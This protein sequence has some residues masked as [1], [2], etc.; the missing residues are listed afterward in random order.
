VTSSALT[1][2]RYSRIAA[3]SPRLRVADVPFNVAEIITQAQSAVSSGAELILFPELSITG[4]TV[5]DLVRS[6]DLLAAAR[7]GLLE[8]AAW[9]ANNTALIVVGLPLAIDAYL[10]NTAAVV[11]AGSV[12]G[13]VPK[14]F[15]PSTHEYYEHRW[16][17]SGSVVQEED[18]VIGDQHIPF[19]TDLVFAC[20]HDPDC[21]VGIEICEDLWSVKP[22]SAD[23]AI[24][25]ATVILNP[26]AS[27]ELVGKADYRRSLVANQAARTWTAYAYASCGPGESTTDT[28]FSGHCLINEAGDLVAESERLSLQGAQIVADIDIERLICERRASGTFVQH[29]PEITVRV[30]EVP[31]VASS[32]DTIRKP[33]TK[34]P[35]VPSNASERSQRCKEILAMQATAL[36]VRMGH[37]GSKRLVL[38][39]SGGLDS[40]L[41]LLV[42]EEACD[43]L[44]MDR[45]TILA[46]NMPGFGTSQRTR[47]NAERLALASG[48]EYREIS[49]V[50]AV[51]RH[52]ADIGHRE[53]VLDVVFE[54][55]QARERTQILMDLANMEGG[56]VVGTS[57]MSEMALGW[58]TY[59]ADHMSMYNVNSGV[60]KTL[61]RHLV[62][63]YA[64]N[65]AV[66]NQSAELGADHAAVLRDV[67]ATPVSPE[68]LPLS[69]GG[70][71]EQRTEDALGPYEVH[72]FALYHL[73]R[74]QR[75]VRSTY[76]LAC[77]VFEGQ[78]SPTEI[79]GWMRIFL[80]RFFANQFKRSCM[81]DG[82]KIGSVGLSPRA[83]WR[84]PSDAKNGVWTRKLDEAFVISRQ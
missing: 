11:C 26:S 56:I 41:A 52:F 58:S 45:R 27:N 81:P 18:V 36:A 4:Y 44:G 57:D 83:D 60:P 71:I 17:S 47:S 14:T 21:V 68:L 10:Y 33:L 67:L 61:V 25:G 74:L 73:V 9:S 63:W 48:A 15:L 1:E 8:I 5:G 42:C 82:V 53:D 40:T 46:V 80:E 34:H 22:P 20:Q 24:A 39:L 30:I 69:P 62:E 19:G 43:L 49:I 2:L 70:H 54:N 37:T 3:I 32:K 64:D 12:H 31:V 76:L 59:N 29:V 28:I 78:Y 79:A 23:L 84:M 65:R 51:Q 16:F 72:D 35:F 13:I 6:P 38:G 75:S 55:A 77:H 7:N 50:E 66:A